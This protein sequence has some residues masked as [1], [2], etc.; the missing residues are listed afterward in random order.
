LAEVVGTAF[1]PDGGAF[2]WLS[3]TYR[4]QEAV[5]SWPRKKAQAAKKHFIAPFAEK[6][7]MK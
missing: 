6:A 2:I 7:S 3:L 1:L 4:A 5:H